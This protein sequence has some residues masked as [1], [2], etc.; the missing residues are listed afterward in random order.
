MNAVL[1]LGFPSGGEWLLVVVMLLI[2]VLCIID[3]ARSN[4]SHPMLKLGWCAL[5][6]FAPFIGALLY[7]WIGTDQKVAN[8][9]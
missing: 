5:I 3:I 6:I 8:R 9:N 4:F 1:L 2:P 7:Y